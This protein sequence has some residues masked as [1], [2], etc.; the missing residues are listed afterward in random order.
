MD[1]FD[2][3]YRRYVR[4]VYA[5][6]LARGIGGPEAEDLTQE[7]LLRAWRSFGLLSGMAPPAQRAW[8]V[9][10]LRNLA[11]DTWRRR[12][13]EHS[14]DGVE[15]EPAGPAD[16]TALRVDVGRAL[17]V[18]GRRDREIVVLRYFE[19][20]SSR[21]IGEAMGIPEG[22]VRARLAAGRRVL[23]EQLGHWNAAE[24][25]DDG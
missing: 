11:I 8:L 3:F 24:D 17:G 9:R 25:C 5:L 20:M 13:P 16:Q 4:L 2:E 15:P 14:L 12:R 1:D 23:A 7:T 6:A 18:L 21:E 22:T 19:G 10:T